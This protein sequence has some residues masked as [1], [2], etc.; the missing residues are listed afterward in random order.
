M[1]DT[2]PR[3]NA[4]SATGTLATADRQLARSVLAVFAL[5]GVVAVMG[6]LLSYRSDLSQLQDLFRSRVARE[7]TDD[8]QALDRHLKLLR[9]EL[10]RLAD[11]PEVDLLDASMQPERE[12]LDSAHR[13]S[14]LF[15]S[16]VAIV[17]A[18]GELAWSEPSTLRGGSWVGGEWFRRLAQGRT[19][20]IELATPERQT[21][22]V[23]VP[24]LRSGQVTGALVGLSR[25]MATALSPASPNDAIVRVLR[26]RSGHFTLPESPP[27]WARESD[28]LAHLQ[29]L[30][31]EEGPIQ[32]EGGEALFSAVAH[33]EETGITLL[34]V[35]NEEQ[36]TMP[37]R[38]RFRLQMLLLTSLQTGAVLLLSLFLRRTYASFLALER[39]ALEQERLLALGAASSLIAHEVK[40]SLNGLQAAAS[41]L[42]STSGPLLAVDVSLP[43]RS[44]RGEV[45]RLKHLA[46]SLLLFGRPAEV[47]LQPTALS[48]LVTEVVEGLRVLPEADEVRVEVSLTPSLEVLSDPLLL[49][50]AVHNIVRNAVE[51]AVSA[52]DLGRSTSPH[53]LVRV[54]Q[55]G[56]RALI[57]VEDNAGG[58]APEVVGRLFEPFVTGK[59]KGI[60]LGLSMTRRAMEAQGGTVEYAQIVGGSRF[61]LRL[62]QIV[63][64]DTHQ[65]G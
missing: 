8:A 20:V 34:E 7:S 37:V 45:D 26:D 44:I 17:D 21:F 2:A 31:G 58:V 56:G 55:R 4:S 10:E 5:A 63:G 43:V 50:T 13:K 28:F 48:Q 12:L 61:T 54:T 53:V 38:Y 60:G 27:W 6:P 42:S 51:A 40:N 65:D 11:R 59:P 57:E 64:G 35:G 33:L 41:L 1:A 29:R 19:P 62:G 25:A 52:K 22:L 46:S 39:R 15:D 36:I 18:R 47:Q 16:G 14:T 24:I 3:S 49:T 9:S 30:P 23:A 32:L